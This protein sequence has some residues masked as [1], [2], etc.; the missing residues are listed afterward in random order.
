MSSPEPRVS[1][2]MS[3]IEVDTATRLERRAPDLGSCSGLRRCPL[4][5]LQA[6][7]AT[8]RQPSP[9]TPQPLSGGG[10][11]VAVSA[12]GV[13]APLSPLSSGGAHFSCVVPTLWLLL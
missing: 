3:R 9:P 10:D 8:D 12:V 7:T 6:T 5:P 2:T 11:V 4:A 13:C 1:Q